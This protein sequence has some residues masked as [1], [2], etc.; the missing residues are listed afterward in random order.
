MSFL[1]LPEIMQQ[2]IEPEPNSGC[3]LWHAYL[4]CHGYGVL[5]R[6]G[7][8]DRAHRVVWRLLVGET[9][10]GLQLDHK[11]R[12][13]NC[14]NPQ[15]LREV[16]PRENTHAPGSLAVA[17]R[18]AKQTHCKRGHEFTQAN[19]VK[20]HSGRNCLAC[21]RI[22]GRLWM[23]QRRARDRYRSMERVA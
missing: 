16:T 1:L 23:A 20:T 10:P 8:V 4:D 21:K 3:W 13:R 9:T 2:H 17:A 19:T 7:K 5:C 18:K 14:C 12:V 11:C 15:H 6:R 22:L